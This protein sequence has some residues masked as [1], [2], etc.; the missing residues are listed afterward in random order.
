M[1]SRR[2]IEG[3]VTA[4][5]A[6]N[7]AIVRMS[8]A[9]HP[10]AL[11]AL[12]PGYYDHFGGLGKLDD[13]LTRHTGAVLLGGVGTG[14]RA[15]LDAW[16]ARL[17]RR[18]EPAQLR[19]YGFNVDNFHGGPMLGTPDDPDAFMPP[20]AVDRRMI[21]GLTDLRHDMI[22]GPHATPAMVRLLRHCA[23]LCADP[24]AEFRLVLVATRGEWDALRHVAPGLAVL[25]TIAVP[26]I[27]DEHLVPMWLAHA[28]ALEEQLQRELSLLSLV[29]AVQAR[30]ASSRRDFSRLDD[31][32]AA[33][34][35][36]HVRRALRQRRTRPVAELHQ[37]LARRNLAYREWIQAPARLEELFALERSVLGA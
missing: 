11:A 15:L 27:E 19:P 6:L 3:L 26:P 37:Y 17:R 21:F 33:G 18:G 31:L 34:E 2:Y 24:A 12:A 25:P 10:G 4:G 16:G 1:H 32:V 36:P 20:A 9:G 14:R 29:H 22:C 5:E 30:S 28:P 13:A 35:E 8:A 7:A 23:D